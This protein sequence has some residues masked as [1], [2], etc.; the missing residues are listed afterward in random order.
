MDNGNKPEAEVKQPPKDF[1]VAEIWIK[2][3]TVA[4]DASPNFWMDKLRAIGILE[5]CK[6]IVRDFNPQD[7]K[8]IVNPHGLGGFRNFLNRKR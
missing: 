6:D 2:D 3:G 8:R 1:K 5:Y 4:L 7:K